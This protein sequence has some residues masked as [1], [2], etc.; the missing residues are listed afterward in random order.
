M[1]IHLL[2]LA[3]LFHLSSGFMAELVGPLTLE[4]CTGTEYAEF[5]TCVVEGFGKAGQAI[6]GGLDET[7]INHGRDREL[8]DGGG[9]T[10]YCSGCQGGASAGWFCMVWCG[11]GRR[12][13]QGTEKTGLRRLVAP[14]FTA[15]VVGGQ[16]DGDGKAK[17]I[18]TMIFNCLKDETELH[19]CLGS[20]DDMTLTIIV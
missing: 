4:K 10:N 16:V 13:E 20:T 5:K 9:G 8:E 1:Q 14:E 17:H 18:A 2:I 6:S 19:P 12:L 15:A 7:F 11:T 3:L